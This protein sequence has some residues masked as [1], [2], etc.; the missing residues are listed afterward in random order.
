MKT[1]H[2]TLLRAFAVATLVFMVAS[3]ATAHKAKAWLWGDDHPTEEMITAWVNAKLPAHLTIADIEI[4]SQDMRQ[5]L[6]EYS[7]S[8]VTLYVEAQEHLFRKS[9]ELSDQTTLLNQTYT[10]GE[11]D[12]LVLYALARAV[13]TGE[14]WDGD[15]DFDEGSAQILRSSAPRSAFPPDSVVEGSPEQAQREADIAEKARLEQEERERA[16]AKAEAERLAELERIETAR[17]E[18]AA[19][20][21]GSLVGI[22]VCPNTTIEIDALDLDPAKG[23]GSLIYRA[24]AHDVDT[25]ITT[26]VSITEQQDSGVYMLSGPS[27]D[28][29]IRFQAGP[30]TTIVEGKCTYH[31]HPHGAQPEGMNAQRVAEQAWLQSLEVGATPAQLFT[32]TAERKVLVAITQVRDRGFQVEIT[33]PRVNNG[34]MNKIDSNTA[35]STVDVRFVDSPGRPLVT[36]YVQGEGEPL[37]GN[38]CPVEILNTNSG[39][40]SLANVEDWGCNS[41]LVLA[42]VPLA[43]GKVD[44]PA[45]QGTQP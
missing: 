43:G 21:A 19:R 5:G 22:A 2:L 11:S 26:P 23:T 40:L 18:R 15:V 29:R 35:V 31:L 20:A 28:D 17:L 25:W 39:G 1:E 6:Q 27:F 30:T 45:I 10:Q 9:G 3:L 33:H 4:Q 44:A 41:R 8:R 12:P 16:A 38:G 36:G 37:F 13:P 32:K 34:R 14:G 42:P 7:E 24:V